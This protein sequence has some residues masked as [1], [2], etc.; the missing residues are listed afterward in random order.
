MYFQ[1]KMT[2]RLVVNATNKKIL[3]CYEVEDEYKLT[4]VMNQNKK[5]LK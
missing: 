3:I 1:V 2:D 4:T 5:V